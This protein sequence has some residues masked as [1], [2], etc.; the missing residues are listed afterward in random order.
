MA[1]LIL[2]FIT[3]RPDLEMVLRHVLAKATGI[4]II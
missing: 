4:A 2:H 1:R 3:T